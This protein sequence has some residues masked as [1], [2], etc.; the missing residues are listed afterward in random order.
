MAATFKA[1]NSGT[2]AMNYK[3]I[4]ALMTPGGEA[5][6]TP[7]TQIALDLA[8]RW[9]AHLSLMIMV[10]QIPSHVA[11]GIGDGAVIVLQD[12]TEGIKQAEQL[13]AA[14]D[15]KAR[16]NGVTASSTIARDAFDS[17]MARLAAI[18][19][20]HDLILI[21]KDEKISQYTIEM[22]LFETG[23]PCLLM[24]PGTP[25]MLSLKK[26]L[27]AWDGSLPSSRAVHEA[28][29]IL[30]AAK[31]VEIVTISG[32]KDLKKLCNGADLARLLSAH[33]LT[34]SATD[35]PSE[36]KAGNMILDHA[37]SRGAD[38]LVAGAYAHSRLRQMFF[39]GVTSTV[40]A[41]AKLPVLM[42]H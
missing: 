9:K 37:Q 28:M 42:A 40:L 34:V 20:M 15:R 35:L 31:S 22:A 36:Y 21:R 23:R 1:E 25:T 24:P 3:S 27:I 4:L 13:S 29:P 19:R 17:N 14:I 6:T 26:V 7:V 10:P 32:E 41:N 8:A 16:A 12:D 33:G 39:G 11:S 38:L 5:G 2:R 30:L 18:G